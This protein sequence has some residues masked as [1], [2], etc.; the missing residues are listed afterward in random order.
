LSVASGQSEGLH[1]LEVYRLTTDN[2]LLT[3]AFLIKIEVHTN[4]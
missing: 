2:W 4:T 1:Y 3:T